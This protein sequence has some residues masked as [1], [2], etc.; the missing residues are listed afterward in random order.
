MVGVK[1]Y[2][3]AIA[4]LDEIAEAEGVNRSEMI[5]RILADYAARQR[6]LTSRGESTKS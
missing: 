6:S 3:E 4:W 2:P 1:L 5:R